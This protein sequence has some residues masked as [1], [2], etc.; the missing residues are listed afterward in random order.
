MNGSKR[1]GN[2][3]RAMNLIKLHIRIQIIMGRGD[4]TL[5]I[6]SP[7]DPIE[8][9]PELSWYEMDG[10]ASFDVIWTEVPR[11]PI[12]TCLEWAKELGI[13]YEM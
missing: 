2:A 5:M 4:S 10:V 6:A 9:I 1:Y 11:H 7:N 12:K 13:S 3:Q 8:R